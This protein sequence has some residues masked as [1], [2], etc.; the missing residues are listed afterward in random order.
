MNNVV[1]PW[2]VLLN[3]DTLI[4]KVQIDYRV[5]GRGVS[6]AHAE[7]AD[8]VLGLWNGLCEKLLASRN[9]VAHCK[10]A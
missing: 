5:Y 2:V 6:L 4:A 10:G 8:D 7:T 1:G 9:E 3:D